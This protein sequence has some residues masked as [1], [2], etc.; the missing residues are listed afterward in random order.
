METTKA[1]ISVV[2]VK[3]EK[4]ERAPKL[5]C[6]IAHFQM[7][8]ISIICVVLRFVV[9]PVGFFFSL[10]LSDFTL[11]RIENLKYAIHKILRR[12][13]CLKKKCNRKNMKLELQIDDI[14][15]IEV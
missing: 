5:W 10:L 6:N 8:G 1:A 14:F 13:F 3:R 7:D 9:N 12:T 15:I 4:F 11:L 2:I